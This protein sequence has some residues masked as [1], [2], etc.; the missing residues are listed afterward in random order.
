MRT[1][2]LSLLVV[3][4]VV[5]LGATASAQVKIGY[6][7]LQRALTQVEDGKAAKAKLE[8]LVKAKQKDFDKMQDDLKRVKD[9]LEQQAAIMKE[10]LKRQKIQDYQKKLMELQDF[11]LNNQKELAEQ[12]SKLT[13]PIFERFE[14]LMGKIA[15]A[16]NYTLIV[17]KA[18]TVYAAPSIDLT[19]RLIKEFNASGGK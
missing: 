19:D 6:V 15:T 1:S 17:E 11:Y 10:D 7:D 2:L 12:E 8:R 14:K 9:E 3:A 18:A 5:G 4:L 13:K 16:E